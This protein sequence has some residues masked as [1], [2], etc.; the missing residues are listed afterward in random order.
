MQQRARVRQIPCDMF[1]LPKRW[2]KRC[3]FPMIAGERQLTKVTMRPFMS[4][5]HKCEIL[6]TTFMHGDRAREI[7]V[8]GDEKLHARA[9]SDTGTASMP[10]EA[11]A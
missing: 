5:R 9:L 3:N 8:R 4:A 11:K 1:L 10:W 7:Q 2:E 6:R